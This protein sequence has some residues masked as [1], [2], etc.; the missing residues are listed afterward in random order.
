[1]GQGGVDA[2]A[3]IDVLLGEAGIGDH[4]DIGVFI[5]EKNTVEVLGLEGSAGC[6]AQAE[7]DA[8]PCAPGETRNPKTG[9]R[10]LFPV[11][12]DH[13]LLRVP[14]Q[15]NEPGSQ[16]LFSGWTG[17]RAVFTFFPTHSFSGLAG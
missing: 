10:K 11:R 15:A 8:G 13:S 1:M 17:R 12:H 4:E 14:V 9:Q 5:V 2:V 7:K 6:G 16:S 3:P